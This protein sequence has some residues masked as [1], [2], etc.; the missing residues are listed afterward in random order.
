MPDAACISVIQKNDKGRGRGSRSLV[1]MTLLTVGL[2]LGSGYAADQ[3][4]PEELITDVRPVAT[5]SAPQPSVERVG[6]EARWEV[7]ERNGRFFS[8]PM[9]VTTRLP[10]GYPRP[11]PAGAIEIKR[12][13]V[14]R[15]ATVTGDGPAQSGGNRGFFPLFR[16]ISNRDIPMTAP[17]EMEYPTLGSGAGRAG[18]DGWT[19]AFLYESDADG[20][21][22]SF[23]SGVIVEDAAPIV[24]LSIGVRGSYAIGP[25][26]A[27]VAELEAWLETSADWVRGEGPVRVLQYNGPSMPPGNRWVEVQVPIREVTNPKKPL[28][29][30]DGHESTRYP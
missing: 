10:V 20:P 8:G 28:E 3:N 26:R 18:G 15:R 1:L 22:G 27:R 5:D 12:Y 30:P 13:P 21:T 4:D 16:H 19:M 25:L 9:S 11:T 24:V 2:A 7:T 29:T 23:E 17:V 14:V 6:G